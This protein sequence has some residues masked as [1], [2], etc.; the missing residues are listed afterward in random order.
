MLFFLNR[1]SQDHSTFGSTKPWAL[2]HRLT[3]LWVHC[4]TISIC[5]HL[6]QRCHGVER[7]KQTVHR[8]HINQQSASDQWPQRRWLRNLSV[9]RW[10]RTWRCPLISNDWS[11][12]WE[13]CYIFIMKTFCSI[14]QSH[15]IKKTKFFINTWNAILI[16]WWCLKVI[17][18]FHANSSI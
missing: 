1:C 4:T 18:L 10:E 16:I 9:S 3:Q 11:L 2:L 12:R 7:H 15:M 8:Q 5:R 13:S 14:H 6:D 17:K